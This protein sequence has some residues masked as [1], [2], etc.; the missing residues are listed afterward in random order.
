MAGIDL[1][2]RGKTHCRIVNIGWNCT[3]CSLRMCFGILDNH[4]TTNKTQSGN[5]CMYLSL[6]SL[7]MQ[8]QY[9]HHRLSFLTRSTLHYNQDNQQKKCLNYIYKV[10]NL[11]L[12]M[13]KG[14]IY[15][16]DHDNNPMNMSNK[17]RHHC[18]LSI[19]SWCLNKEYMWCQLN[20]TLLH[21]WCI[22]LLG[23]IYIFNNQLFCF[24]TRNRRS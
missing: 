22:K 8:C 12:L 7:D 13:S 5:E 24:N 1:C 9:K 21:N 20:N 10:D 11:S 2:H 18:K 15:S 4:Q 17:S 14:N 6:N 23:C 16:K 19:H 3:A